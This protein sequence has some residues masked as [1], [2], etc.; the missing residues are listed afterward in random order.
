MADNYKS[1]TF[2]VDIQCPKH[3]D[4]ESLEG[5]A[6][7]EKKRTNCKEC[8]AWEFFLWLDNHGYRI[9]KIIHEMPDKELAARIKGIDPATVDDLTI[10][11]ILC[12]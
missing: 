2:C 4:L 6:Y 7:V 9:V 5:D 11:E 8:N 3:K 1:G 12:L 10:E